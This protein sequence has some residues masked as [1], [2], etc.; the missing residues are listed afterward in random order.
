MAPPSFANQKQ[1]PL[2]TI[3]LIVAHLLLF[4]YTL[5]LDTQTLAQF[6]R[7]W[8]VQPVQLFT[9]FQTEFITLLSAIFLHGSWIQIGSNS[10]AIAFFGPLVEAHFRPIQTLI[11]YLTAGLGAF[12]AQLLL[13]PANAVPILGATGAIAGLVGAALTTSHRM[14]RPRL[15][16]T[17]FL[18]FIAQQL[19][20]VLPLKQ[21]QFQLGSGAFF[22]AISGIMI[23]VL[24][25]RQL[26]NRPKQSR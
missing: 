1:L 24:L 21:M 17:I 25:T 20:G 13:E 15:A 19:Y 6:L 11:I 16:A 8:A 3:S 10:L 18:W 26:K 9:Q 7:Q 23:G 4:G 14:S 22:A 2:V 12:A 5:T